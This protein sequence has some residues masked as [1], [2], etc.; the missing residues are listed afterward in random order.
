MLRKSVLAVVLGLSIAF[1]AMAQERGRIVAIRPTM[2]VH[3]G[4][5]KGMLIQLDSE[6]DGLQNR[7]VCIRAAFYAA[8]GK[9]LLAG[10]RAI[11]RT[12]DGFVSSAVNL[13]PMYFQT[14]VK[15][16]E[17]FMPYDELSL[18]IKGVHRFSFQ[19]QI[20][21]SNGTNWVPLDRSAFVPFT[22][23]EH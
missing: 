8:D 12:P 6:I 7:L 17:L 1:P 5:M 13:T 23:I 18:G 4:G 20:H 3:R 19:V 10:P 15:N 21:Y 9:P 11:Y 2:D 16:T 22:L 14:N